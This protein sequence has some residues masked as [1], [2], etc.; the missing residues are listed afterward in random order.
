M[1]NMVNIISYIMSVFVFKET[2]DVGTLVD[3]M[4]LYLIIVLYL[5]RT[6]I[7]RMHIIIVRN[8]T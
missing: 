8:E 2:I 6:V 5:H 3:Y 4:L 7:N 1:I